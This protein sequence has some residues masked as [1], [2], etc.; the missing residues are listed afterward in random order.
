ML[1]WLTIIV[2]LLF[3]MNIGASG[4][5]ATMGAAYGGGAI[6]RKWFAIALVGISASA[7]AWLAGEAV[8]KTLSGGIIPSSVESVPLSLV[9]LLAACM[10]LMAANLL[11]IPLSTSEVTVGS[12]VGA[13]VAYGQIYWGK[14]AEVVSL[15][16]IIPVV[17]FVV[18]WLLGNLISPIEKVINQHRSRTAWRKGLT[19]F[20]IVAGCY[21]AF[22]A[23][24]NNLANAVGPL[25]SANLL[26]LQDGMLWGSLFLALGAFALGARVLETNGKK[27]TPLSLMKGT[28]VS[29]TSGSLVL[30]ASLL[31]YPVPLTQATTMAILGIGSQAQGR[32]VWR[33]EIVRRILM[34][35]C[36]SPLISFAVSYVMVKWL[37]LGEAHP[38]WL[39]ACTFGLLAFSGIWWIWTSIQSNRERTTLQ[40]TSHRNVKEGF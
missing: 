28:A 38:A 15:W 17:A 6:R 25:I 27:I 9:I 2:A 31:G 35:W 10:T 1:V 24:A 26:S 21:E 40:T 36:F 22:A 29:L 37:V 19:V 23:G 34:V 5:A 12:L 14:V 32:A 3:A 13:G 8:V 7:G 20:L 16:V 18:A 4:T 11:S 30:G 33:K 39:A